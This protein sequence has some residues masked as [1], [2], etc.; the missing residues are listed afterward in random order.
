M[1]ILS[2]TI[3]GQTHPGPLLG[4]EREIGPIELSL[5]ATRWIPAGQVVYITPWFQTE[6]PGIEQPPLGDLIGGGIL[7]SCIGLVLGGTGL[8]VFSDWVMEKPIWP[9]SYAS[10]LLIQPVIMS[11]F[12]HAGNDRLGDY[13]LVL[14][15]AF[16]SWVAPIALQAITK[17]EGLMLAGLVLQIP[18]TVM[19]ER[20][21]AARNLG[22]GRPPG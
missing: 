14:G 17:T 18:L 6:T 22:S 10:L 21:T 9:L 7:G 12:V 20:K 4:Y 15:T 3:E 19:A 8:L 16:A 1:L 13:R 5:S 2:A 11:F